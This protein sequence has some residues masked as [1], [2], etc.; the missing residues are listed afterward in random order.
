[1]KKS[2]I[3]VLTL[4]TALGVSPAVLSAARNEEPKKTEAK[5]SKSLEK[6]ATAASA[7]QAELQK[8]AKISM[9]KAREIALK[10]VPGGKI[11]SAEL[12]REHGKL[13]YSFDIKTSKPGV[14][15]VN[16]DAITGKVI[17][18]KHET[19]AKE[20]AEKKQEAK[21]KNAVKH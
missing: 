17:S 19:P 13:I 8:E 2:K 3:A 6:S 14:M 1:M 9:E 12:E 20:A 4:V 5:D 15:E 10:K 16:V 7:T 18:S 11:E 21:E